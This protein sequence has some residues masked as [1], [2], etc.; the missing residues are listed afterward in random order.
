MMAKERVEF[1]CTIVN[2]RLTE[3]ILLSWKKTYVEHVQVMTVLPQEDRVGRRATMMRQGAVLLAPA[4]I[5]QLL[6]LHQRFFAL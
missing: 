4:K 1:D 3:C 6:H 2:C 5:P